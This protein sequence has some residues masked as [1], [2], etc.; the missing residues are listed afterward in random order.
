[1]KTELTFQFEDATKEHN[2]DMEI[3]SFSGK[4]GVFRNRNKEIIAM[5][6]F[7]ATNSSTGTKI[8]IDQFEVVAKEIGKGYGRKCI[9]LLRNLYPNVSTIEG[10]AYDGSECFWLEIG[11]D[12]Y[13]TCKKCPLSETDECPLNF[14]GEVCDEYSENEFAITY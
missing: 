2:N 9:E 5:I 6:H 3:F 10:I 13:D 8:Y 7:T 12:F 4:A 14:G 1:M 11:A